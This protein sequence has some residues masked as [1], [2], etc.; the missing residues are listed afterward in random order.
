MI[1]KLSPVDVSTL[2]ERV[3]LKLREAI[4]QGA[5][6][7]GETITIRALAAA[8]GTS[9]MPV[10]EALQRLVA[11][12]ALVQQPSRSITIATF[13]P[14]TLYELLRIRM[15]IEG[16]SARRAA[17]IGKPSL[18]AV[19]RSINQRMIAAIHDEDGEAVL[20]ANKTFHF[21]IY[22]AAQMP[23][24]L[25]I[26]NGLWLRTGPY[27]GM[28]YRTVPGSAQHFE[29]GT[30]IHE[31]II[32]AIA[33]HDGNRAAHGLALDIWLTG[34]RFRSALEDYL[35]SGK[36]H[37]TDAPSTLKS[38]KPRNKKTLAL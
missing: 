3:Y 29:T 5:F 4:F 28:I 26:I 13:T 22:E 14:E 2:Q 10:R 21:T 34:R 31:R 23:Q 25:D 24:L 33:D 36:T 1:E 7:P 6:A 32:N 9:A 20:D 15:A 37:E 27:L 35:L 38:S 8:L 19:L 16:L 11:E 18:P 17:M 30:L 12:K